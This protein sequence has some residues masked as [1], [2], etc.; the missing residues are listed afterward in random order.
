MKNV[1][2]IFGA[3]SLEHE[4]SLKSGYA[5]AKELNTTNYYNLFYIGILKNGI[6]KYADNIDTIIINSNDINKIKINEECNVIFQIGNGMINNIKIDKAFLATHGK[7]GEDGNLQGFLKVNNIPYTGNDVDGSVVCYNKNISKYVAE[8]NNIKVVPY[9]T[10]N[11]YDFNRSDDILVEKLIENLKNEVFGDTFIVKINKGGSSIG[12]FQCSMSNLLDTIEKAFE[13][14][15]FILIEKEL[16][17]NH[18]LSI[19]IILTNEGKLLISDIKEFK[20]KSNFFSFEKKYLPNKDV[21][22][23]PQL[24]ICEDLRKKIIEFSITLYKKLNLKSYV[25]IDYF[26][27][28]KNNLYFNEINNLSGMNKIS[29]FFK[30]WKKN[31]TFLEFLNFIIDIK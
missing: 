16:Y 4:V 9:I 2:I 15:D 21:K 1:V 28:E 17:N 3:D 18:E 30:M 6:W 23:Y 12:V 26:F 11:K 24:K 29:T 22:Y 7:I 27:D 8:V 20:K 5:V 13:I 10:L 25:R 19:S 14:D 31:F